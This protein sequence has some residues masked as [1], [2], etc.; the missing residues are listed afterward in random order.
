M[1]PAAKLNR[2][3]QKQFG[4]AVTATA[5]GTVLQLSGSL[6]RWSQVVQAGQLCADGKRRWTLVNDIVCTEQPLSPI[7]LPKLQDN[8]LQ[9]AHPHVLIIG[10]G[11]VGCAIARELARWKLDILLVDKEHDLAL[12]ASSRNDGMVHPG[13]D[14]KKGQRKQFYNAWG[15]RLYP[16]VCS[17]L[18]VDFDRCGQYVC[19]TQGWM[20][21]LLHLI[22]GHWR[23]MG[24][25]AE[26][27]GAAELRQREPHL[28]ADVRC[29][30]FFPTAGM[31]CPYGLTIAYGENAVQNG[32]RL[33]LDTAV[34]GMTTKAGQITEVQTNRGTVTPGLVINAAGVFSEEIARMAKDRFF[35]IHPRRGTNIILDKK[36]AWQ[37]KTIAAVLSLHSDSASRHTKGGGMVSTIDGNL[38]VGPDAQETN[39][40]ECFDTTAASVTATIQKQQKTSPALSQRDLITCFSGVRAATYEEDFVVERGRSTKNLIHAAGIQS[41]GLTAAP[42]I[43]VDVAAMAVAL[44][45]ELG[46]APEANAAFDP[47]RPAIPRPAKLPDKDRAALIAQNPDFGEIVCRC[48]EISRGEILAALHRPVPCDTVDGVKRRVR[49]GMGRCQGGFCGP[50]VCKM[51]AEEF[52]LPLEAVTKNGGDSHLLWGDTKQSG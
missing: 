8:A 49:P 6:P 47:V 52:S 51:I 42:A 15:N 5:R 33:S 11:V 13:V 29:G 27:M 45:G 10:G 9:G 16:Q 26:A 48:E 46:G 35:S 14:L 18:N 24:V 28:A 40:R 31:V 1:I 23:R 4:S 21:P 22:L 25:P 39:L 44:L 2:A 30:L 17:E 20:E 50:L 19:F 43:G 7:I 34:L 41:P 32:V 37:V 38:L 12:H 3:L 36:A